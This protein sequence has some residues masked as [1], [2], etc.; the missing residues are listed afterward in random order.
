[1]SSEEVATFQNK[2]EE[3][4]N[5]FSSKSRTAKLW[6]SYLKYIAIIKKSITA[7]RTSNWP[8]HLEATKKMLNLFAATGHRNCAKSARLYVRQM[9]DLQQKHPWLHET[10]QHDLHAVRR[11]DRYWAGLWSDLLIEQNLMQSI[12]TRGGPTRGRDM[13]EDVRHLWVL[14]LS[15]SASIHQAMTDITGFTV[16]SSVHHIEME[17]SRRNKDNTDCKIFIDWLRQRNPFAYEDVN[18][19]S[20]FLG[21]TS[22]ENDGINCDNA[23]KIGETIQMQLDILPIA[24][25][26][27]K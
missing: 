15:A 27:I 22:Y 1:M 16:K 17:M 4:C 23:E 25:C 20:L 6:K 14:S 13:S 10:F 12:K 5:D 2:L 18:L 11:S 3:K 19:H 9:N 21:L 24:S 8:L 7:E 26:T